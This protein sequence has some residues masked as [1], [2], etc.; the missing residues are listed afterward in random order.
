MR[1][2]EVF[3]NQVAKT[4]L[5]GTAKVNNSQIRLWA[6]LMRKFV[7]RV[8]TWN[9][10][11]NLARKCDAIRAFDADILVVQEC[12]QGAGACFPGFDFHWTGDSPRKGLGVFTRDT[13]TSVATSYDSTFKYFLP[14]EMGGIR[15]LGVWAFNQRARRF[16]P[17]ANGFPRDALA[18]YREWLG[19]GDRGV[20]AGDF[21][22]STVWDKP[23]GKS[24][25]RSTVDELAEIGYQSAYHLARNQAFGS[26]LNPT[27]IF[28]KNT[29][30]PFHIDYI[31][32]KGLVVQTVEVGTSRDWLGLSDHCPIVVNVENLRN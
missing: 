30:Q 31:F 5:E 28:R 25:F 8:L 15:I 11:E 27:L 17:E 16:G 1:A 19:G 4:I 18:H 26:E 14:I 32:S 21:N 22:N 23:R 10:S 29:D 13:F 7:M 3:S 2:Y 12:E 24:N 6:K 9:C 20:I